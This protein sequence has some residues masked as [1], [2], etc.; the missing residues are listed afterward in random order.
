M[1]PT[2]TK[3]A[4]GRPRPHPPLPGRSPAKT[5]DSYD[6]GGAPRG[7]PLGEPAGAVVSR[8]PKAPHHY[9]CLLP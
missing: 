5:N 7:L 8:G 3:V 6:T 2:G 9:P 4:P 1:V